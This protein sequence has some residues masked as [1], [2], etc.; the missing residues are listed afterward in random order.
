MYWL[1]SW[2]SVHS[3]CKTYK[4]NTTYS[5][6]E[7]VSELHQAFYFPV[8]FLPYKY[9]AVRGSPIWFEYPYLMSTAKACCEIPPVTSNYQ[10]VGEVENLGDLPVYTVGNKVCPCSKSFLLQSALLTFMRAP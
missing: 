2:E 1:I 5:E 9:E 10:A 3:F 4:R 8:F 7:C 6:V